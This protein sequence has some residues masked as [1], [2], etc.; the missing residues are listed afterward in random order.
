MA[1]IQFD[2]SGAFS[3][4]DAE[5]ASL[6]QTK[7][8]DVIC[9]EIIPKKITDIFRLIANLSNYRCRLHQDDFERTLLTLVYAA[10]RVVGSRAEH[11]RDVWAQT[12]VDLYEAIKKD[13]TIQ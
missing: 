9:E 8:L 2:S 1:G 6:R 4:Q 11:Q 7:S 3:V 10:Q 12:F 13:L 5:L